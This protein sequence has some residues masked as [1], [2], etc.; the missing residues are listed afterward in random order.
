MKEAERIMDITFGECR[1]LRQEGQKE[2]AHEDTN[3]L[4]NFERVAS[5]TGISKEQVLLVYLQKHIDGISAYVKGHKSQR[6]SISGRINDA[7]V[8]LCLLKCMVIENG[9]K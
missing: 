3:A 4:A 5:L 1:I 7:I 6:E 9:D 2:Y 8:Y